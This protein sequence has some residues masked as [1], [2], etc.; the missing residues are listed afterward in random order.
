MYG[1]I[2]TIYLQE[3]APETEWRYSDIMV[4]G[5]TKRLPIIDFLIKD[6]RNEEQSIFIELIELCFG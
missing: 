6:T 4:R 3:G 2:K 5:N 1:T